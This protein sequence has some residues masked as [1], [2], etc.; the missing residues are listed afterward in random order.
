MVEYSNDQ[1]WEV[2]LDDYIA[3]LSVDRGLSDATIEAYS[4]DLLDFIGFVVEQGLLSPR[5][6]DSVHIL[7]WLEH[8]RKNGIGPRSL[9]RRISA[10]RGFFKFLNREC[11]L[12]KNPLAKL[13]S[14]KIGRHLPVV[15]SVREV[16]LLLEQPNVDKPI[17]CRDRALLELVYACGLRASEAINIRINQI[18]FDAAFLRVIG[19]GNKERIIPIG[20][21]ALRWVE[22][23]IKE[24]RNKILKQNKSFY[25]FITSSGKPITRQRFWQILKACALKAG[26]KEGVTPHVLRH[27]FATHLLEGGADLRVVQMLLGHAYLSTTQIY[28]HLDLTYLKQIHRRYHPRG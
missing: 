28:T 17:G 19:K 13:T 2:F 3:R 1:P 6:V 9:V 22:K 21:T 15:L 11:R 14:P 5:D 23:Y 12:S 10:L 4:R 20:E 24:A 18:D 27:S 16:E 8:Q 26:L 7:L 25:L